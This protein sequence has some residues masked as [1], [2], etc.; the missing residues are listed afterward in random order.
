MKKKNKTTYI[1]VTVK[2]YANV[3]LFSS[4]GSQGK[5]VLR[6]ELYKDIRCFSKLNKL[7]RK[8]TIFQ[9]FR[10]VCEYK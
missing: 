10:A 4:N 1:K 2:Q 7:R 3:R 8:V 9:Y 5:D 6:R